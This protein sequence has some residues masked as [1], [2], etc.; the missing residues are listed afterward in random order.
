ME[1]ELQSTWSDSPPELDPAFSPDRVTTASPYEEQEP[2]EEAMD[3]SMRAHPSPSQSDSDVIKSASL[4][5]D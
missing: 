3:L 4:T 1:A 2:L 5:T